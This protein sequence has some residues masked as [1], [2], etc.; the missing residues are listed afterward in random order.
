MLRWSGI[1]GLGLAAPG[2]D[3]PG[4]EQLDSN[5]DNL[6]GENGITKMD[7][8]ISVHAGVAV[9]CPTLPGANQAR[10]RPTGVDK[11]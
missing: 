11:P 5:A 4:E 2:R 7:W 3:Q 6:P 10:R 9:N 8:T 1:S